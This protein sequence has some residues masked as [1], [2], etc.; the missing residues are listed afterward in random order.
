MSN[1][2]RVTCIDPGKVAG[3]AQWTNKKLTSC[4][5]FS[6]WN[7][8]TLWHRGCEQYLVLEVPRIYPH[9][10]KGDPN[11]IVDLA[12]TAGEIRGFARAAGCHIIEVFPRTWKG[13]VP[14]EIHHAR[15]LKHL[16]DDE[17]RLLDVEA[18]K[19]S[20]TNPNGYDHN[21]LDAVALGLWFLQRA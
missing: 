18:R 16:A 4:G 8:P 9:R 12:M 13:Q 17:L 3:W 20:K 21:M 14:K 11:D 5:I 10:S 6:D 15:V 1:F 7:Y 2:E 19:F